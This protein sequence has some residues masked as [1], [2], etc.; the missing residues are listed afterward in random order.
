M[1][2][3]PDTH[4]GTAVALGD[5]AALIVGP[6]GAGK[7]DLA[8][9]AISLAPTPLVPQ[10]AY[11]VADDRVHIE[12]VGD[13]LRVAAPG[14]IRGKLEVRGLGIVTVPFRASARLALIAELV[15]PQTVERLPDPPP[16]RDI[17]SITLPVVRLSAFEASAPAKL[18][19]ALMQAA[20]GP[21][22]RPEP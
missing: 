5:A 13:G 12:V 18:L 8:L 14:A 17:L 1:G 10:S 4:H 6:P 20:Q 19:L 11:L 15:A 7:S 3:A 9:R 2:G 16:R 21:D 22:N